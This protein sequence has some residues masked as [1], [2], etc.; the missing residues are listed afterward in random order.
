MRKKVKKE[1]LAIALRV[2]G[3]V[4]NESTC[5][6]VLGLLERIEEKGGAMDIKDIVEI[7]HRLIREQAIKENKG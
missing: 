5:E 7:K 4:I 6:L 2:A 3:V 1:Y